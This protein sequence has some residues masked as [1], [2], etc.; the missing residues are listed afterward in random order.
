[1]ES[2]E[3]PFE[4]KDVVETVKQWTKGSSKTSIKY[5]EIYAMFKPIIG[6]S[7]S[8]STIKKPNTG[9]GFNDGV[10]LLKTML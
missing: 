2:L 3:A 1:L 7:M 8:L 4:E 5:A 6:M 9:E 10:T